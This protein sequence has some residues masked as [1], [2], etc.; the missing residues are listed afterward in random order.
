MRI[1]YG[2]Q[3]K[4]TLPFIAI[5]VVCVGVMG[6]YLVNFVRDNQTE[7]LRTYLTSEAKITAVTSQP[8][9]VSSVSSLDALAKQ[10]GENINA[11]VT[12]IAKDGTVLGD[13]EENPSTMENHS[14]R[15]EVM[16]ALATGY[17]EVVRFSTTLNEQMMYVAVPIQNNSQV[18]GISRIALPMSG[19]RNSV[20]RVTFLIGLA[21]GITIIL[22]GFA[23]WFITR[24]TTRSIRE[25]TRASRK[26]AAGDLQQNILVR[27]RDEAGELGEAFN[28]MANNIRKLVESISAEQSKLTTVLYN[29]TDGVIV[30]DK[31]GNITLAN[32][33]AGKLFN[34]QAVAVNAK[35]VIEATHDHEVANLTERCLATGE[36][37]NTQVELT[38]GKYLRVVAIPI[39]GKVFSGSLLLFQDLTD[40]RNL[41]TM[42]RELVGNI[43]HDL[44][45]P[46]AG[47]K[48]MVETLH[49]GAIDDKNTAFDFL[50]RIESEVDR[51]TQMVSELT[52]LSRIEVGDAELKKE[53]VNLNEL[54]TEAIMQLKP[55]ADK[56]NVTLNPVLPNS[57]PSVNIDKERLSQ[58]I[59][60]LIHNAIKFNRIGGNVTVITTSDD[61]TVTVKVVDTGI[62][63]PRNSLSHVFE[64]FYKS[65][66]SRAERG[67][68]L[69]LAI[70][71]H[72]IEAHGG[73]IWAQSEEGKGSTF[74]FTIPLDSEI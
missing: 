28:D 3:W 53:P 47:I 60:N 45:T 55:L 43:S 10:L 11:R 54:I 31:E 24:I 64:R 15:P 37:F 56:Q 30:T 16:A 17:G 25:V 49:D 2:I 39:S 20:N 7:N 33:T 59:T 73:T 41:Q 8:F 22:A 21:I 1:P 19:V 38:S 42:R 71:K 66:K 27:S 48:V 4:I 74:S 32:Q 51:L 6:V 50:N 68:G 35:T 5:I 46:L 69:G 12:I 9:F 14:T 40:L 72:T 62:G 65:D 63:I 44:R 67:S 36:Q 34:F 23:V 57:L 26:M 52:G 61:K 58:T 29:M 13:S 18:L 70:A